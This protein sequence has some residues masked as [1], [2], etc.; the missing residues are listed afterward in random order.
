MWEAELEEHLAIQ[1]VD[2]IETVQQCFDQTLGNLTLAIDRMQQCLLSEG[3]LLICGN[4]LAHLEAIRFAGLLQ[5]QGH[6]ERPSL[7]AFALQQHQQFS[8]ASHGLGNEAF[9]RQIM[10]LGQSDDLLII[11]STFGRNPNLVDAI[12]AAR[13]RA[14]QII[15]F[16]GQNQGHLSAILNDDDI[17]VQV[18]SNNAARIHESFHLLVHCCVSALDKQIFDLEAPEE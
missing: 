4:G 6:H 3:K 7:P 1:A 13:D 10:S 12:S 11:F 9:G 16:S 18:P 8:L 14:M 17:E 5:G 15:V 2:S